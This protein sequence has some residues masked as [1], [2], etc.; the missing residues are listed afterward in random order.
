MLHRGYGGFGLIKMN[1]SIRK[2]T[3]GSQSK[4]Q[5]YKSAVLQI[6][7]QMDNSLYPILTVPVDEMQMRGDYFHFD[8]PFLEFE[9]GFT[10]RHTK[11]LEIECLTSIKNRLGRDE[12]GFL[13]IAYKFLDSVV[14][15]ISLKEKVKSQIADCSDF[16]PRGF[17]HGDFGFA[18]MLVGER[19]HMIDFL[20]SFIESPLIDI[21]TLQLSTEFNDYKRDKHVEIGNKAA[22][23]VKVYSKHIRAIKSLKMLSWLNES[24]PKELVAGVAER[25]NA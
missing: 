4:V 5:L 1:D 9:S 21:A 14:C 11:K 13:N 6:N 7:S 16:Y 25:I 10:T 8:M 22:A 12:K 19:V 24:S 2:W 3:H 23:L 17:C 20:P 15:D 18:N